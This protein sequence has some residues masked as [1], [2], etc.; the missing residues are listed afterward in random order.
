V[1]ALARYE[2]V[3]LP[4]T[5]KV[6]LTNRSTPP[7]FINIKVDEL[8]QGLPFRH[9]DDVISQAELRQISEDYK[10]IAGFSLQAVQAAV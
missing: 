6:V 10:K 8:T 1:D 4:A 2:A 9:I 7:D 5:S 3:R